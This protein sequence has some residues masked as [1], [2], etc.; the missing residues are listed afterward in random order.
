MAV[1][2]TELNIK[3][4]DNQLREIHFSLETVE[5]FR[6]DLLQ[7]HARGEQLEKELFGVA[8]RLSALRERVDQ[9]AFEDKRRAVVELVKEIEIATEEIDGKNTAVV[10]I[11]YRF[12]HIPGVHQG[13]GSLVLEETLGR[14]LNY[15][16]HLEI[17]RMWQG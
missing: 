11:T 12:D 6:D 10:T 1:E 2:S 7:S 16:T 14:S 3:I 5:R 8:E 17:V 13:R 9:A 15:S 4:L